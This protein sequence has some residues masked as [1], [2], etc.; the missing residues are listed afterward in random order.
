M[1]FIPVVLCNLIFYFK[2]TFLILF[3][4]DFFPPGYSGILDLSE[5]LNI[6]SF[7]IFIKYFAEFYSFLV[8][9]YE[10]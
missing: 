6:L 9:F 5:E 7:N 10:G 1:V 4:L 2:K 3:S 8:D